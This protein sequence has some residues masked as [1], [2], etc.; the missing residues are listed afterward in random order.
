MSLVEGFRTAGRSIRSSFLAGLVILVPALLTVWVIRFIFRLL[1]GWLR[2]IEIKLLARH[3]PGIGFLATLLLVYLLGLLVSNLA[4]RTLV[5]FAEKLLLRLPLIGDVY[6]SSK[7]I[8]ETVTNP[9]GVG[10]KGVVTFEFP[11]PGVRAVGFVTREM[12][13]GEGEPLYAL[14]MPHT[15]NPTTGYLLILPV[16]QTLPANLGVDEAVKMIVSGGVVTPN[17]FHPR[18]RV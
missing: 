8:M 11:R 13:S 9:E 7:Q 17:H 12:R 4:G 10:F 15:P 6:G 1:D 5:R 3:I 14:F 18:M 16:D 2:P